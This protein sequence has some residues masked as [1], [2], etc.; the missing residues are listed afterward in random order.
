[1]LLLVVALGLVMFGLFGLCEARWRR[2]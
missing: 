1:V 2:T